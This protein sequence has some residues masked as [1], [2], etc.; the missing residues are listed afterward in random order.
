MYT[1]TGTFL[2]S[3]PPT[4]HLGERN[5]MP[6][7]TASQSPFPWHSP[8]FCPHETSHLDTPRSSSHHAAFYLQHHPVVPVDQDPIPCYEQITLSD[9]RTVSKCLDAF[10]F[11]APM[12]NTALNICVQAS[13]S[14]YFLGYLGSRPRRETAMSLGTP[15]F[16][17]ESH[18]FPQQLHGFT[19]L[20]RCGSAPLPHFPSLTNPC[21]F[22]FCLL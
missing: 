6:A 1:A 18:G 8:T 15:P 13:A 4:P 14:L 9:V 16:G 19:L 17:E 21:H 7:W 20:P 11:P 3:P 12:T 22:L 2:S 10:C 5:P